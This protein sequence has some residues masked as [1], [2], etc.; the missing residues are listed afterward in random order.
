M[1]FLF[2]TNNPLPLNPDPNHNPE[3]DRINVKTKNVKRSENRKTR[4]RGRGR[5]NIKRII[6]ALTSISVFFSLCRWSKRR[7]PDLNADI[8]NEHYV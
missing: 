3:T 1:V 5:K 4:K 8:N 2:A 6:L 7:A